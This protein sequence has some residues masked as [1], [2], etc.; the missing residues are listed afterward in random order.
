MCAGGLFPSVHAE[1]PLPAAPISFSG[2][3]SAVTLQ[4]QISAM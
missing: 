1:L 3:H 4:P 2:G